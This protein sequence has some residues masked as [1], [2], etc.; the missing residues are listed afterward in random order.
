MLL[1]AIVEVE[2]IWIHQITTEPE[3]V[4]FKEPKNR[5]QGI[6]SSRLHRAGR[7]DSLESIPELPKCLQI[8]IETLKKHIYHIFI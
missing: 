3:F 1:S 8:L 7:I 6:D 5:F 2:K 4:N